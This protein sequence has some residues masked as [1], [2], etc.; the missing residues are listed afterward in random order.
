[1]KNIVITGLILI[2]GCHPDRVGIR[3]GSCFSVEGD[4]LQVGFVVIQ[5]DNCSYSIAPVRNSYA[6][7]DQTKRVHR[8][9]DE[10]QILESRR[11]PYRI[12]DKIR[13]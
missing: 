3:E 7:F 11:L 4:Y 9:S 1:M 10:D 5:S 12:C 2:S 8:G 13:R 6:D